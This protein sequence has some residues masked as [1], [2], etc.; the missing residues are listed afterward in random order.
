MQPIAL[1]E[2]LRLETRE[3]HERTEAAFDAADIRSAAGLSFVLQAHRLALTAI[4]KADPAGDELY[5]PSIGAIEADLSTLSAKPFPLQSIAM[6]TVALQPLGVRYVVSG[7]HLGARVMAKQIASSSDARVVAANRYFGAGLGADKFQVIL[8]E[9]NA[10]PSDAKL[11]DA[12][13]RSAKSAFEAYRLA[14]DLL[15]DWKPFETDASF[16]TAAARQP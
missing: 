7:S 9:L 8:Q 12:L 6:S 13:I 14:A 11:R 5:R 1:R 16:A 10:L 15:K 3:D 2:A 4:R